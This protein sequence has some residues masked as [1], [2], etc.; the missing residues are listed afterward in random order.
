MYAFVICVLMIKQ[1]LP[2][3]EQTIKVYFCDRVVL[4]DSLEFQFQ[5]MNR[6][7]IGTVRIVFDPFENCQS[8]CQLFDVVISFIHTQHHA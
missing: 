7:L 6:G 3:A 4:L 5:L 2:T 8:A 1:Q